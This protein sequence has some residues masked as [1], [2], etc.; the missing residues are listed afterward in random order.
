MKARKLISLAASVLLLSAPL[1][2]PAMAARQASAEFTASE[3]KKAPKFDGVIS[4]GEWGDGD[5][6]SLT[7]SRLTP[8]AWVAGHTI[9]PDLDVK[10]K[11]A[12]DDEYLY[13][14]LRVK[15]DKSPA[16]TPGV[17]EAWWDKGDLVQMFL[18]PEYKVENVSPVCITIGFSADGKPGVQRSHFGEGT[19]LS[20]ECDGYSDK[21]KDTGYT[22]EVAIPWK[23][24]LI[25]TAN[26]KTSDTVIADGTKIGIALVYADFGGTVSL[27]KTD[28][29]EWNG[30]KFC[31]AQLTLKK[32][33]ETAAPATE[34]PV[35][36]APAAQPS[37]PQTAD[38]SVLIASVSAAALSGA[39]LLKK[40]HH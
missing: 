8:T 26:A 28:G 13:A 2:V 40:K 3:L 36:E 37:A 23:S 27:V 9:D 35:T 14:A 17:N 34:A 5:W 31:T 21:Y 19:F 18:N 30:E 15:G 32:A 10:V 22:A 29:Q 11:Y 39:V 1:S 33:A 25:D 4:E 12:W 7:D 16:Q 6:I 38:L 24:I 20:D